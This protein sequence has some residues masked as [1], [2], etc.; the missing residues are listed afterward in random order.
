MDFRS[1]FQSALEQQNKM[2]ALRQTVVNLRAQGIDKSVLLSELASFRSYTINEE[3]EDI[4]LEIMDCLVGY[5]SPHM[6]I[7]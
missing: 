6:L 4:V 2:N 1:D 3:D 5:C 7:E